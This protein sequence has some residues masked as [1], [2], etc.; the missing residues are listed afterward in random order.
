MTDHVP[1]LGT[2]FLVAPA[3]SQWAQHLRKTLT[4]TPRWLQCAEE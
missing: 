3:K 4:C 2:Q 1:H